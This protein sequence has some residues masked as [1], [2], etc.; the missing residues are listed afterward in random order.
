MIPPKRRRTGPFGSRSSR[1]GSSHRGIWLDKLPPEV[2]ER[3]ALHVCKVYQNK[4]GLAL[5]KTS[6][7]M[8]KAVIAARKHRVVIFDRRC[9]SRFKYGPRKGDW[10]YATTRKWLSVMGDDLQEIAQRYLQVPEKRIP[11]EFSLRVLALPN[12]RVAQICDHP[13]HLAAI[14]LSSSIRELRIDFRGHAPAMDVFAAMSKLPLEKLK[15]YCL[16]TTERGLNFQCPFLDAEVTRSNQ[17]SK[18]LPRIQSI[19]F[20]PGSCN[21]AEDRDVFWKNIAS[22]KSLKEISFMWSLDAE[23]LPA[24]ALRVLSKLSSVHIL[25][26]L[27]P[28][29][30]AILIGSAVT[31]ISFW[32]DAPRHLIQDGGFTA[33]HVHN[34]RK[35][36]R[37]RKLYLTM[38]E[39]A[40]EELP[41]TVAKLP[42]LTDLDLTW[43]PSSNESR[44]RCPYSNSLYVAPPAGLVLRTIQSA[45]LLTDLCLG[46]VRIALNEL[47]MILRCVGPRLRFFQT[48][49]CDQDEVPFHRLESLLCTIGNYN[50]ELGRFWVDDLVHSPGGTPR[51]EWSRLAQRSVAALRYLERLIPGLMTHEMDTRIMK[52]LDRYDA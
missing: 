15:T 45:P 5:A 39:G 1:S 27:Y 7:T 18:C 14:G 21:S 12:L 33:T 22:L 31:G 23:S 44:G 42:E 32:K 10:D 25:N 34:M 46:K 26:T 37:L 28:H 24:M 50:K 20:M 48:S 29:D 9:L 38:T 4:D 2:C 11:Y 51:T 13:K 40:E 43:L 36:P 3:L 35:L 47:T 16:M 52:M 49:I 17:I 6:P 8:R 41:G 19:E 30:L